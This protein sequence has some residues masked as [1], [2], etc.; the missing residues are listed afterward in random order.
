MRLIAYQ[1]AAG[2][3]IGAVEG[4]TVRPLAPLDAFYADID[5]HRGRRVAS[6]FSWRRSPR[7]R[8]SRRRRGSCVLGSTTRST[9]KRRRAHG[10][11]NPISLLDGPR[12]S[13]S[14]APT[15]RCHP[16]S[17]ALTGRWSLASSSAKRC[18]GLIAPTRR[19]VPLDT[20]ASTTSRR[21]HSS[22]RPPNGH[23]AR[24]LITQA[25]SAR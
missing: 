12:P 21:V 11:T 15:S 4:D 24:T 10:P 8:R 19:M 5:S 6:R 13:R 17:L 9:S 14:M 1:Q 23:W 18:S 3:M 16:A 7:F 25:Q 22:A 2:A 20:R